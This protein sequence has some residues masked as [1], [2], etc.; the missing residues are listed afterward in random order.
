[1]KDH[2]YSLAERITARLRVDEALLLNLAAERSDFVRFNRGRVRQ[3][4]SVAQ[5]ELTLRLVRARRQAAATIDIAGSGEDLALLEETL[6]LLRDALDGLPE[7]PWLLV[8]ETPRSSESLRRGALP[9]AAEVVGQVTGAARGRDLVGIYAA[10]AICRGF[11]NSLGQRNWHEADSFNFDW[12][13]HGAQGRAVKDAYAGYEWKTEEF[14]DRLE[15]AGEQLALLDLPERVIAPGEVR[16]YL[17]PRALEELVG[18]LCWGGFSARARATR[19][20]P[21]LR[22]QD[23]RGLS[24]K[25]TLIENTAGGVAPGFQGEGFV[26]PERVTLIEAGRLGDPLVSP[27]SAKEYG[28][29]TNA[30][31]AGE[32]PE[33]LELAPGGLEARDA[34][35]AL[36][37]GLYVSNFWYLNYSDR[38][39]GRITG[40]TRFATFWVEGGCIAAPV[41]A[42]RFDDTVYRMLGDKLVDL[43]REREMLLDPSTYGARSSASARLP[44]ALLSALRFTL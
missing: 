15:R 21:L 11:A 8:N 42:M 23:G 44:G 2:F 43:T 35:E 27:R 6:T 34:L 24:P 5:T 12:S 4:G 29:A 19:Q 40:M 32:A 14:E 28:L 3:A 41:G 9:S 33:S 37:E 36:G 1:M 39:A 10:G 17:A 22:M 30:A 38:A 7:D 25:V 31:N 13:L 26:R 20:S 18:M 16:A